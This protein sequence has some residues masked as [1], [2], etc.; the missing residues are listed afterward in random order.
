[1][2]R[3]TGPEPGRHADGWRRADHDRYGMSG[4]RA[5]RVLAR[6]LAGG[7]GEPGAWLAATEH[8]VDVLC[9]SGSTTFAERGPGIG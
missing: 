8:E 7:A 1:M 4:T 3:R 6:H 5:T 9:Y 2:R